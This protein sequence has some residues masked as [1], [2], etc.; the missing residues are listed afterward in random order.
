MQG[1]VTD[2]KAFYQMFGFKIIFID[3]LKIMEGRIN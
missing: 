1:I 3:R 2:Q